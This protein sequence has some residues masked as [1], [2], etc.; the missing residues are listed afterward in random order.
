MNWLLQA[1]KLK[2]PCKFCRGE[3]WA[4]KDYCSDDCAHRWLEPVEVKITQYASLVAN[5]NPKP[6]H[7]YGHLV[8]PNPRRL[9][10]A[11]VMFVC[12][13][14]VRDTFPPKDKK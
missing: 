13:W 11:V 12:G 10:M 3:T 2:H 6:D 9:V 1:F 7:T 4:H 14:Q 8:C 5:E